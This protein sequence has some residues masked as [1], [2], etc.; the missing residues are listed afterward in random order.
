MTYKTHRQ[1]SVSFGLITMMI[2]YT[3]GFTSINYYAGLIIV[4]QISKYGALFPDIDH[5]WQ[6]VKDKTIPN[7]IINKFIHLT[8]GKHRSWQ[9]HSL[10]IV[11]IAT[12]ISIYLPN[13]LY[14]N[15]K[16]GLV[17]REVWFIIL[18]GFCS[19]WISHMVSD[20]L[21][22]AGV[23]LVCWKDFKLALVP[24]K[25]IFIHFK[26]GE[27]WEEFCYKIIRMIN[28]GIGMLS[29]SYPFLIR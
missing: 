5:E 17:D 12:M 3:L 13:Y 7:W 25:F 16:I 14:D 15:G 10:D 26:T 2:L 6:Y 4:L 29:I 27:G 22:S 11:A 23:R 28:L 24:K 21:T 18:L 9:T 8:N 20:M 1:F 19:G